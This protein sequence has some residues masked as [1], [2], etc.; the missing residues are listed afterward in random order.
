MAFFTKVLGNEMNKPEVK[1]DKSLLRIFLLGLVVLDISKVEIYEFFY[2]CITEKYHD[3]AKLRYRDTQIALSSIWEQNIF[4]NI[5]K[6][7]C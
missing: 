6:N 7:R 3:H 2:D 4:S 5:L 1:M